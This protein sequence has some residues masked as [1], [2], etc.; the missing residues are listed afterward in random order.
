MAAYS[1]PNL[2][3]RHG[4]TDMLNSQFDV[5]RALVRLACRDNEIG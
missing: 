3:S 2:V 4:L 1:P 5:T